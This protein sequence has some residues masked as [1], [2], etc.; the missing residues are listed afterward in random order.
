MIMRALRAFGFR[1]KFKK[2][3]A[4]AGNVMAHFKKKSLNEKIHEKFYFNFTSY[5]II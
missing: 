4:S 2:N 3:C 5:N 1:Y